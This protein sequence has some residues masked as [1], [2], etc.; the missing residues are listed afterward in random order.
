MTICWYVLHSK[1]N[2]EELLWEQLSSRKVETF[3]PRIRVQTINPRARKVKPYFPGYVFIHADLEQIAPST[4]QW[5]PGARGFVSFDSQP[6]MMS[7][8][9]IHAV[10]KRVDEINAAGGELFDGLKHGDLVEIQSGPFAGY[11]AIFDARL[12]GSERVRVLLK[13]LQGKSLTK[14]EIPAGLLEHKKMRSK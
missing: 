13:M 6:A 1:P 8:T 12:P 7:D 11:E 3:Y 2:H 5:M 9:L 10:K 14:M 4:L